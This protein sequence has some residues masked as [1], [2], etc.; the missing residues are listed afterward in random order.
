[1]LRVALSAMHLLAAASVWVLPWPVAMGLTT[2]ILLSFVWCWRHQQVYALQINV[3][4]ELFVQHGDEWREAEVLSSSL[5]L[6][7]LTVLNLKLSN[8]RK[9]FHVVLLPDSVDAE[10]FRRLRVW[11]KWGGARD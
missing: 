7:Y 5:V 6:P 2:L 10:N 1:M 4:G 9:P 8:G 11:L 3:K